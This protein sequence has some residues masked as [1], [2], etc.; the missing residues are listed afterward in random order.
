MK[1]VIVESPSK[2]KKV[3]EYLGDEYLVK[4]SIGHVRDLPVS[5]YIYIDKNN[6]QR[7]WAEVIK[8]KKEDRSLV[9]K[10]PAIDVNNKFLPL[11]IVS[12]KKKDVIEEIRK[13]ANKSELVLLATDPDREGEAIAWHIQD[14]CKIEGAKRMTYTEITKSAIQEAVNNPRDIDM[15]LKEAQEARRVLDRL[16]GYELSSLV[17]TKVRYGLSAGRVQSPALRILVEREREILAFIPEKYFEL[18]AD[19]LTTGLSKESKRYNLQFSCDE[20][21]KEESRAE[22]IK[23]LGE[24]GFWNI[25]NIK[26]TTAKRTPT[27]PLITSSLQ[28]LASNRCGFSPSKTMQ[29]AQKLYQKGLITYMRTDSPNLSATAID[30]IKD[31]VIKNYGIEY[32][33][34]RNFKS[35]SKNAQEAHEAIRPTNAM[36]QHITGTIEEQKI[37][38]LIWQKSIASQMID[39][40]ILRTKVVAKSSDSNLPTFSLNGSVLV[41]DGWLKADP[42][43]RGEEKEL[44]KLKEGQELKIESINIEEKSTQPPNR[45][46]EAGLIKELESRGIG[47]PATFAS[48]CSTIIERGYVDKNGKTLFPTKTGMVVSGFIEDN[49]TQYISDN[50]TAKL[51]DELDDIANGKNTYFNVLNNF[52][53]DFHKD[54]ISKKDIDKVTNM[55]MAPEHILCPQCNSKMVEKISRTGSFYSCINYPTCLGARRLDGSVME[56][57]KKIDA[58][59]PKCENGELVERD[60]RFGKFISCSNYPKCKYIAE[61]EEAKKNRDTGVQ[62]PVCHNANMEERKGRF[63]TFYSC[64]NYPECKNA[65]KAKPTGNLCPIC[66]AL[67]MEGTKTIPERCSQKSCIN[68]RPDKIKNNKSNE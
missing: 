57:P 40:E 61:D 29:I 64:A 16:F 9:K 49:F 4:A 30:N 8:M 35:K 5:D 34:S 63:G 66:S 20:I 39:A 6:K 37:Y 55:D 2:I 3:Q 47:R 58:K 38:K 15:N 41:K 10:V 13:L 12:E 54:I 44:P 24:N 23:K 67:M 43:A 33:N 22:M 32:H 18:T 31:T 62:C 11:Y 17:W 45:Y 50:F 59:C 68:H 1:L 65:I 46:T 56:G 19:F 21:P 36:L 28:Q 25:D 53:Q 7:K 60:G 51:E 42:E 27:P 52:Y 14:E 26:E 48:I